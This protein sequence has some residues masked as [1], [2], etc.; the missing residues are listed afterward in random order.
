MFP[1]R[2]L[3]MVFDVDALAFRMPITGVV[4]AVLEVSVIA[5]VDEP[6]R[7]PMVFPVVSP[8]LNRPS[9]DPVSGA[10]RAMAVKQELAGL[11]AVRPEVWLMP[12]M[13]F[14]CTL[15][16]V[17]VATFARSSPRNSFDDPLMVVV[18]VPS[19][20]PKPMIFPVTVK[21]PPAE[22]IVM[23]AYRRGPVVNALGAVW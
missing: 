6:S 11:V 19:A 21:E 14:P 15:V 16:D 23:P 10:A 17:V 12:E 22:L 13:M 7:L 9:P 2:L 8:T 18:P 1:I 20:A 5:I 4:F 3:E